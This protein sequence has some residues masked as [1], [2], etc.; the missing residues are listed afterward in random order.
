[1]PLPGA[2]AKQGEVFGRLVAEL[3]DLPTLPAAVDVETNPAAMPPRD[4]TQWVRDFL[5]ATR[6]DARRLAVYTD[7]GFWEANTDGTPINAHLWVAAWGAPA[8]PRLK[9]L[10]AA[11][12]WQTTARGRVPGIT[13]PVD[14][15][16]L[17]FVP[18]TEADP[19]DQRP[20]A[21]WQD[22]PGG[23]VLRPPGQA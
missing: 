6:L 16:T 21:N 18:D 14:L 13:G 15:D 2:A 23:E 9:G 10:P 8:P 5:A 4:L 7:P 3:G 22:L 19:H 11:F 17:I 1:M 20:P 12:M